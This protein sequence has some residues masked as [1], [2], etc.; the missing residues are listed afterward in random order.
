MLKKSLE[1]VRP[2]PVGFLVKSS[3]TAPVPIAHDTIS[4]ALHPPSFFLVLFL[5]FSRHPRDRP[6]TCK[7]E[8]GNI[9]GHRESCVK[10]IP[11]QLG[12][13]I[14]GLSGDSISNLLLGPIKA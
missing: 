14:K 4:L 5:S 7:Y 10:A 6:I 3:I 8:G 11:T 13:W 9:S 2:G 12:V 1:V